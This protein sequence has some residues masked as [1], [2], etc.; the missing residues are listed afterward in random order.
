MC[1]LLSSAKGAFPSTPEFVMD[2]DGFGHRLLQEQFLNGTA[3]CYSTFD[4]Q[5]Q[6]R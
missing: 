3:K 2:V 5:K 1:A 4:E 6:N